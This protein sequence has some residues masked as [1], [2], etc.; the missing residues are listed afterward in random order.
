[1][2]AVSDPTT[3]AAVIE[4]RDWTYR[5]A[6][7]AI[8]DGVTLALRQGEVLALVGPNGAGKTTLL[9]NILR[10]ARGG[11]GDIRVLG[12]ALEGYRQRD[13]ARAVGYVPQAG[14]AQPPFTVREYVM[15]G[16]YPYLSPLTP[17]RRE[18]RDAVQRALETT[19]TAAFA[20]RRLSTLSGGERQKVLIAAALAQGAS[21]LLL[22]EPT[23]FLDPRHQAEILDILRQINAGQG[24]SI[25]V[26]THDINAAAT[27]AH[28]V[29]AL[30]EGRVAFTGTPAELM[31]GDTLHALFDHRFT[32]AT[33][34]ETGGKVVVP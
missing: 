30:R 22:D 34:P 27:T 7:R 29:V 31:E 33:H 32:L 5:V 2:G 8:L 26:V 12:R 20:E 4:V 25:L 28:R 10:I 6:G 16:R 13:L 23:T 9:R 19:G 21:I 15:L 17:V 18:D 11:E 1:V 24:A 14:G 3:L